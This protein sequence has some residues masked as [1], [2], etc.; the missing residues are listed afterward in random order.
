M[1]NPI[2]YSDLIKPDSSIEELIKELKELD[3]EYESMKSKI[4]SSAND[5]AKSLQNVSGATD[6]QRKSIELA[7]QQTDKLEKEYRDIYSVQM[8]VREESLRLAAAKKEET[9]VTKLLQ[10]LNVSAE[11]SY[12]RLSAQYRL[13]KIRLNEMSEAERFATEA[14]RRLE[15]ETKA[16]YERMN[17]LQK[18]TGKAQ[19]Q[20]GQ[21]E[22]ALGGALG[23]NSKFL[24]ILTDT[25]KQ[26]ETLG[27][28]MSALKTPLMAVIALIASATQ[29]IKLYKDSINATRET[30]DEFGRGMS[31]WTATVEVFKKA[32]SQAD[33]SIFIRN[34][35][36]SAAAARDLYNALDRAN[37]LMSSASLM[38]SSMTEEL[39]RLEETFRNSELDYD[40]RVKAGQDYLEK[41]QPIYQA[42]SDAA[43]RVRDDTLKYLYSKVKTQ[44]YATE[45]ELMNDAEV[46]ASKLRT[47][48]QNE[49][50]IDQAYKYIQTQE[51]L[52]A[53]EKQAQ[54]ATGAAEKVYQQKISD[55]QQLIA[56]TPEAIKS[57][58]GFVREYKLTT[59]EEIKGY[60]EA[61][62][63]YAE[64]NVAIY[65]DNKRVST[66]IHS[67]QKQQTADEQREIE[68]RNAAAKKA[69]ED[70]EKAAADAA[71]KEAQAAADAERARQKEIADQRALYQAQLQ[72]IN[73]EIAI[74]R[75]GTEE[76]LDL[77]VAAINKQREIEIFENQQKVET[78]RQDE[79]KINAKY[80]AMVLTETSK[81][82]NA[83]SR[84]E[85][86]EANR[87]GNTQIDLLQTNERK[88]TRLRIELEIERLEQILA[89]N[90]TA[91]EKL[92]DEVVESI[93]NTISRLKQTKKS[94][95]YND[96]YDLLGIN[97]NDQQKSAL[98]TALNSIVSSINAIIDSW[99][100]AADAAVNAA[101]K[102]VDAAQKVLDAQI[103]AKNKG[104]ASDVKQAQKELALAQKSQEKAKKEKERATAVQLAMDSVMQASSLVTASA[105]LW[106]A[107]SPIPMVGPA[108]AIAAITTMWGSFLA[109]KI[110]AGV[111]TK[112]AEQYGEGTVELLEGGSHASGHDIDLGRKK[113][114][115]RRRAE[116]GEYFAVINKRSSRRYRRTIPDVINS[117]NDGTFGD[118]YQR[119][120][121]NMSGYAVAMLGGT[122]VSRL[123]KDVS[124]IRRQGDDTRYFDG[125]ATIVKHK[126]LTRKIIS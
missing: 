17:E 83:L 3:A 70:R 40:T 75:K 1:D 22:R 105:N 35:N 123:E 2:Y 11:G 12:N 18:A 28:A 119:A 94:L 32:I 59:A 78:L 90:E 15:A 92:S 25:Q 99:N 33:F 106:Q 66:L 80:D 41:M 104:Y 74:T 46:F 100:Q 116:G 81:F 47:F 26:Q 98:N 85:I 6:E 39:S 115:T 73:L 68:K 7:T 122:D 107:F 20:V 88:K 64:K 23:V 109:S 36:D 108:L 101:E 120:S 5:I 117:L 37:E 19:L 95:P 29:I 86:E 97:I 53:A 96:L 121:A 51:D 24:L 87:L 103:E 10:Q 50:E 72:S 84:R 93:Q 79:K 124:A 8:E 27:V 111:V 13:N 77:R 62:R 76:M 4:Q 34:L 16:I 60:V 21:Y 48:A 65:Q 69:A 61:E 67:L 45:E 114:G 14:G 91:E 38:R 42:E 52:V 44:N 30:G 118:K 71:G 9:Q 102:Q 56:A 89:L 31:E 112:Q 58:A 82:Y 113:D 57:L 110:Y 43:K 126:N 63:A 49:K 55:Y 125:R 54:T